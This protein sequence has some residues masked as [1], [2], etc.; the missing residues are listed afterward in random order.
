MTQWRCWTCTVEEFHTRHN[1]AALH[2]HAGSKALWNRAGIRISYFPP[3][4][5]SSLGGG[6]AVGARM[7]RGVNHYATIGSTVLLTRLKLLRLISAQLTAH[8]RL[9]HL[10]SRRFCAVQQH[11]PHRRRRFRDHVDRLRW[12]ADQAVQQFFD[13]LH[14]ASLG[15]LDEFPGDGPHVLGGDCFQKGRAELANVLGVWITLR[16]LVAP[17]EPPA[18]VVVAVSPR[19]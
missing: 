4:D 12:F 7:R 6:L 9:D 11:D 17:L 5:K 10:V 13:R 18:T 1:V 2:D 19:W 16:R 14:V 8:N 15:R 3:R